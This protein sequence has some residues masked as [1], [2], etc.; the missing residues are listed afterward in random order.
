MAIR[1]DKK[2]EIRKEY[3]IDARA[4]IYMSA[5]EVVEDC[6]N[7]QN[8]ISAY[9][10]KGESIHKSFHGV[11]SY[12]EAL[13]LLKIG[14]QPTVEELK[15]ELKVAPK[16]GARFKFTN[17]I[18]GFLPV[19]PL[20]LKGVPN[21]MVNM[22][23]SPIKSKVLDVY[24]DMTARC[25]TEPEEFI[26]AG[27]TLLGTIIELEKRG[28]RFNLFALQTYVGG[29]GDGQTADFLCVK[30]KSSDKPIDLKRI[31]FPLTH[32]AFFRVIGFDWQGKSP[33]TRNVGSGRGHAL[34]YDY[35]NETLQEIA[36]GM[37]GSN[38][39]YVSCASFIDDG[40]DKEKLKE[41]FLNEKK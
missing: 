12:D 4:E 32:P 19:V 16:E 7:R 9:N 31:S 8:R 26:K 27:K 5:E 36:K 21:C 39:F 33:I 30:V 25:G 23:M 11:D 41:V 6:K 20:A 2:I 29:Y 37:F 28:Y 14:Y 22:R 18:E 17:S 35:D 34:G 13:D 10:M 1:K 15:G 24:Y 40:Y 38:S 3:R